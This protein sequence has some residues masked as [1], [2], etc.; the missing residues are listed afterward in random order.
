[1][2]ACL[3]KPL[4]LSFAAFNTYPE[5][6]GLRDELVTAVI[7]GHM[8]TCTCVLR[9]IGIIGEMNAYA[10]TA[11]PK[12]RNRGTTDRAGLLHTP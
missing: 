4:R 10:R 2:S 3:S 12:I 1:M 11:I 5:L 7:L 8:S 9:I 6:D